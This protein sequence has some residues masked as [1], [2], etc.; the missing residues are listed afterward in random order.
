MLI[1]RTVRQRRIDNVALRRRN[2]INEGVISAWLYVNDDVK[3][4]PPY[5]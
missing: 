2:P 1:P 3:N 5:L 4:E